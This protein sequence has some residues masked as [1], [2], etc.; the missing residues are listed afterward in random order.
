MKLLDYNQKKVVITTID[1]KKYKGIANYLDKY[2]Y[3][4]EE[5]ALEMKIGYFWNAFYVSDIQSIEV[6]N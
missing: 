1:G 3:E 6:I 5:D 2:D 4:Q